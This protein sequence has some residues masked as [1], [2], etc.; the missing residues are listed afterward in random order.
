M[1]VKQNGFG[2]QD[3]VHQKQVN[4]R[5][6]NR[7]YIKKSK[8]WSSRGQVNREKIRMAVETSIDV[9]DKQREFKAIDYIDESLTS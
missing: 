4:G 7:H 3:A 9:S 5:L 1:I 8:Y 2:V 6:Q